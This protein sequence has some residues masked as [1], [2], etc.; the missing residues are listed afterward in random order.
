MPSISTRPAIGSS[1]VAMMRMVVV[2]PAPFG[3]MKPKIS[4][5]A[6]LEAHVAEHVHVAVAVPQVADTD[7]AAAL[8]RARRST[9]STM[10]GAALTSRLRSPPRGP[11]RG[12]RSSAGPSRWCAPR[13]PRAGR[14][15]R[16]RRPATSRCRCS[17]SVS[18]A[19]PGGA[20][21][22]GGRRRRLPNRSAS[23]SM[24][25]G[26]RRWSRGCAELLGDRLALAGEHAV[27]RRRCAGRT[28][29]RA[30][31]TLQQHGEQIAR[32]AVLH[33]HVVGPSARC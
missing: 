13:R 20:H 19:C 29:R 28:P 33:L 16:A 2:L 8:L 22:L 18:S 26:R 4:P 10:P 9:A 14:A 5:V 11:A 30:P 12:R 15:A 1:S 21:A 27:V 23:S 31:A 25:V 24:R 7:G 3:P 17:A 32:R 6:D